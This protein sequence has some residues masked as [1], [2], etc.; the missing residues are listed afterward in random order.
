MSWLRSNRW[1]LLA[2]AILAPVALLVALGAGWFEYVEQENGR[3]VVAAAGDTVEYG[4][5]EF[6]LLES[7]RV[8]AD[9]DRGQ[10]AGLRPGTTLISATI[11]VTPGSEPPSCSVEL[12]DASGERR[13]AEATFAD[14]D[15]TNADGTESYCSTDAEA[16][17]RLQVFFVVPDDAAAAPKLRFYR[18]DLLP[19]LI[20]FEL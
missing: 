11:G 6:S 16:P 13:W 17:Y 2:L 18:L 12:T 5:S 8:D 7:Y 19:D 1:G 4:G 10:A 3:P 20:L 14:A 15:V 9:S